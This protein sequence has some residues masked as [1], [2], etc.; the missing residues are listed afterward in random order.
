MENSRLRMINLI[1]T[2]RHE[3]ETSGVPWSLGDD[4]AVLDSMYV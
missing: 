4:D 3:A 2:L 1:E